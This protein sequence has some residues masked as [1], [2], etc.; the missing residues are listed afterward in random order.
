MVELQEIVN[1]YLDLQPEESVKMRESEENEENKH[2][3]KNCREILTNNSLEIIAKINDRDYLERIAE[4]CVNLLKI[5]T[6]EAK[7]TYLMYSMKEI[8]FV[9]ELLIIMWR[10]SE[11]N[12]NFTNLL[13]ENQ[14]GFDFLSTIL[15]ILH[16]KF[17]NSF[18][19][20][21]YNIAIAFLSQIS[22][23]RD[24]VTLLGKPLKKSFIFTSLPVISGNYHD[25]LINVINNGIIR[26]FEEKIKCNSMNL[27][28]ILLNLS[29]YIQGISKNS[30]YKLIEIGY[31]FAK[32]EEIIENQSNGNCLAKLMKIFDNI[33]VFQGEVK[34]L[35]FFWCFL[36]FSINFQKKTI[37][38]LKT[39]EKLSIT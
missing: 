34:K 35:R 5:N 38:S 13:L 17:T 22:L 23:K 27:M 7:N 4:N 1:S 3:F 33:I 6:F 14:R 30:C 18:E 32:I 28:A 36:C 15:T 25:F 31:W 20:G 12:M 24:F 21:S 37:F 29:P 16:E 8:N 10:I 11:N 19:S 26:C 9:E 39:K 2:Y